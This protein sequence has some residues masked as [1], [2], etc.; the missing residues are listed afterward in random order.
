MKSFYLQYLVYLSVFFY[1][2]QSTGTISTSIPLQSCY[3]IGPNSP[4]GLIYYKGE[5]HLFY[6]H[7]PNAPVWE[8]YALGACCKSNV[9]SLATFADSIVSDS[10][11]YIFSGS[12]VVDK[13]NSSGFKGHG[14]ETPLLA[15]YTYHNMEEKVRSIRFPD[16]RHR[17]QSG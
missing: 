15:M 11:G 13:T 1:V 10:L 17:I 14:E 7:Y 3:R 6:Q 8:P 16:S 12:A 5:Y 9:D 4:N 2:S